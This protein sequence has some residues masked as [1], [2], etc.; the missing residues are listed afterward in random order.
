MILRLTYVSIIMA[1]VPS[2]NDK[3]ALFGHFVVN[4][5]FC[6]SIICHSF[7]NKMLYEVYSCLYIFCEFFEVLAFDHS[8]S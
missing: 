5:G 7:F 1:I 4:F 3:Q 8:C 6:K 2:G